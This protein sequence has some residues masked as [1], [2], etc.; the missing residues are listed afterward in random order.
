MSQLNPAIQD[1]FI[2]PKCDEEIEILYQDSEI[3]VI[4]K[5]SGL[6]SLSGKNPL[7]QD[8]VHYRIVQDFPTA[9]LTHRLDFGTSGVML[10]ALNKTANANITQQFQQKSINKT[11]LSILNAWVEQDEGMIDLPIAKDASLFPR[12]KIC[13]QTGKSAQTHFKVLN[14]LTDPK[15][16]LVLYTPQTG[17]THQLRIHS[18]AIGHAIL[19]CDLYGTQ[20]T[21]EAAKRMLLHAYSLTFKHPVSG[22]EMTFTSPSPFESLDLT[23]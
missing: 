14:R 21:K 11:Y 1:T 18:Q 20:E 16:T 7:N 5:P 12:L 22:E 13:H 2:A 9:L 6:L 19:G 15:R 17:R 8:S 10:L 23:Y 4:S 3:L